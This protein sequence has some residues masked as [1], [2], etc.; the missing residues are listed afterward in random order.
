MQEKSS[1]K[2]NLPGQTGE[3]QELKFTYS[4]EAYD[5]FIKEGFADIAP[6]PSSE[7]ISL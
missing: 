7:R 4:T 6:E 2:P 1:I 5:S 3:P